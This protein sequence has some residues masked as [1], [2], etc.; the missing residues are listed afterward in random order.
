MWAVLKPAAQPES[1]A[2]TRLALPTEPLALGAHP[3]SSIVE[4]SPDGKTLAYLVGEGAVGQLYLRHLDTLESVPVE[5]GERARSPFFSP[6]GKWIAFEAEGELRKVPVEGGKGWPICKL[7][8]ESLHGGAWREDGTIIFGDALTYSL[9]KVS[10][11]G[12]EPEVIFKG[13]I[14]QGEVWPSWPQLMP[15]GKSVLFTILQGTGISKEIALLDLESGERKTVVEGGGNARYLPT[16][17]LAYA[18]DGSLMVVRFDPKR[19]EVSGPPVSALDGLLMGFPW[20]PP[21]A[22]FTLA[23]NGTLA[24]VSGPMIATGSRLMRVGRDGSWTQIGEE[25]TKIRG[26]R[27]SPDGRRIAISADVGDLVAQLWVYDLERDTLSRV[28]FEGQGWW[29]IWSPDGQRLA[30]QTLVQP[31]GVA[32]IFWVPADG[33]TTPERL[34]YSSLPHYVNSFSPDG[35]TLI[36][37]QGDHPETK[38][39]VLVLD[40]GGEAGET[41]PLLS[42]PAMEILA[43]LSPNGRWLAYSSDE[44]GR[45]EVY[46]RSYPD[47]D[48]KWQISPS[49]GIEPAWSRDGTELFYRDEQGLSLMAVDIQQEPDFRPGRPRVLLE[50]A[51]VPTIWVGRNYDVAP[52]GQSFLLVEQELE[53]IEQAQIQVVLNW[54]EEVQRIAPVRD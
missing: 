36:L 6:D 27:F 12:G 40:L 2:V 20:D 4:L 11:E 54:F 38:E 9:A 15:D 17:H 30:F 10:A 44:S 35:Q 18:L 52:D 47:L 14:G 31:E 43:E 46:V 51:Y 25:T 28:T 32:N 24:Y 33:G 8:P 19:V 23:D 53:G 50:G 37:H 7:Q 21:I 22:H 41:R 39:D 16:G 45:F 3:C 34:T 49:G 1:P 42:S 13:D 5:G 26:P 48:K 29:P